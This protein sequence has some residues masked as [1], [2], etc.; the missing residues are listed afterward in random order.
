MIIKNYFKR[1]AIASTTKKEAENEAKNNV[2]TFIKGSGACNG[3]DQVVIPSGQSW[4]L[5]IKELYAKGFANS[6]FTDAFMKAEFPDIPQATL[7]TRIPGIKYSSP[8]N[9][10]E[11]AFCFELLEKFVRKDRSLV[12]EKAVVNGKLMDVS[13]YITCRTGILPD[14]S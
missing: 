7:A 5:T 14:K 1:K 3:I 2:V 9:Q 8:F 4:V 12:N 13:E 6:D 10:S 11:T